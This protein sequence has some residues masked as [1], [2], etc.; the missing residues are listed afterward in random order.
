MGGRAGHDRTG[1]DRSGHDRAGHDRSEHDRT[2]DSTGD[3]RPVDPESRGLCGIVA[4]LRQL[5]RFAWLEAQCCVFAVAVFVG[6]AASAF[7]WAH[8]DL[9]VARY[10]ALLIYVLVVQ[11]VMLRSGLETRRELLVICG[12]HLVGLALEVFKTAV[13]SWSY[14]QPGVLRVGQVPLFSGFMYASVGCYLC[15]AWRRFDL[16]VSGYH[17]LPATV[18]ALA[19]YANFY[20]HHVIADLR[21]PIAV[22]FLLVLGHAQVHF[23]VGAQRYRMPLWVSFVL[24]G[25][26]LWLAENAGTLLGGWRYPDQAQAWRMVHTGKLGSWAMLV[27]LSFVMVATLKGLEGRL[28]TGGSERSLVRGIVGVLTAQRAGR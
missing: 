15:Q 4:A 24:I 20:T 1:H 26:F 9:P 7:V 12:F 2:G 19:A 13:G 14:P 21:V 16:R 6:L 3:G 17:W 5:L 28:H 22:V 18:L 27:G 11:L 23:T 10:D 8:L 25:F